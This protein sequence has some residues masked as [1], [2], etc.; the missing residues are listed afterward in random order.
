M[1]IVTAL[2]PI[3]RCCSPPVYPYSFTQQSRV[4]PGKPPHALRARMSCLLVPYARCGSCVASTSTPQR[5]VGHVHCCLLFTHVGCQGPERVHVSQ[6]L[7]ANEPLVSTLDGCTTLYEAFHMGVA[8]KGALWCLLSMCVR[9][10]HHRQRTV[11]GPSQWREETLRVDVVQP[12]W[13]RLLAEHDR[14]CVCLC[15]SVSLSACLCVSLSLSYTPFFLSLFRT[16]RLSSHLDTPFTVLGPYSPW[17]V[18]CSV[19]ACRRRPSQATWGV[20]CGSLASVC[21]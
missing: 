3:P 4:L 20:D 19:Y 17:C 12:G 15:L 14:L 2:Q 10:M 5:A 16:P 6:V 7:A 18:C 8:R 21:S 9:H 13:L 11:P 1:W